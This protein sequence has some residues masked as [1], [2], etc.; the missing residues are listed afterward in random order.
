MELG[1]GTVEVLVATVARELG[2]D[3]K[4]LRVV[5]G[6]TACGPY[7]LGSFA[8]RTSFFAGRAA[9]DACAKFT[10]ACRAL[11]PALGVGDDASIE[12]IVEMCVERGRANELEVTGL[13]EP[14]NVSPPDETGYGNISPGYTFATHGCCVR[15]DTL[16]GKATVEQYWAAHDAGQILNPNGA[17]G[18]VIGGVMQ[19]LGFALTEAA[20]VGEDGH[21]LNPGYLDD[22]VATFPD[23]VPIEVVFS[24]TVEAAGPAGAKT[25]AEP[26]IIPVAACVANAIHDALGQRQYHLPMTPERVWRTLQARRT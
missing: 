26:P 7:G 20:A 5:L 3:R 25:V 6:D 15:V 22:R 12:A 17:A 8:S 1:C 23:A 14:A 16:T 4:R 10:D 24:P 13:Y 11:A 9:I 18:Q 2:V 19:G 21:L